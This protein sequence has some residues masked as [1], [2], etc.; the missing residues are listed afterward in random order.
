MRRPWQ[1]WLVFLSSLAVAFVLGAT[2]V[3]AADPILSAVEARLKRVV[4][5]GWSVKAEAKQIVISRD[6]PTKFA[7]VIV[8][9]PAVSTVEEQKQAAEQTRSTLHEQPYRITLVAASLISLADYDK[10][11]SENDA[12][13]ARRE[14]MQRKIAHITHK[15]DDYLA[16]APEDKKLLAEYRA[17]EKELRFHDLPD[18]YST[19]AAF[20]VRTSW[21]VDWEYVHD[22]KVQRECQDAWDAVTKLLGMYDAEAAAHRTSLGRLEGP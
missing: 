16:T 1:I 10:L 4:P 13:S 3:Q 11:K 5:Q 17:Q 6:A 9:G 7:T 2:V 21:R 12:S 20:Q 15:F 8:N 14:A 22:P 19:D 18:L